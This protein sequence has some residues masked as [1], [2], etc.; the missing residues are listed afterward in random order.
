[1]LW[2]C[3]HCPET[4]GSLRFLG[5]YDFVRT[6]QTGVGSFRFLGCYD[7][8]RTVQR[9]WDLLDFLDVMTLYALSRGSGILEISWMLWLCT[10][11]PDGVGSFRFLGCCDFVRTVQRGWDLLDFL[12]V[13][14]LY[15]LPEGVGSFR[16]LGCYDFVRTVQSGWDLLDFLAVM[17]L[18]ALSRGGGIF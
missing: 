4:V 3:T 16:F 14:T 10:R 5:C 8:V 15:A 13:M 18:Y 12:D 9:G 2:L 11:C 17:T 1:M 6:V 7:F